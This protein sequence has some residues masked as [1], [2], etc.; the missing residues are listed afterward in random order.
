MGEKDSREDAI[1]A[2]V[3]AAE[4]AI[5]QAHA[6]RGP[7]RVERIKRAEHEHLKHTQR[8]DHHLSQ[9]AGPMINAGAGLDH[10]DEQPETNAFDVPD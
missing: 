9:Q 1:T 5:R 6:S 3:R 4:H 8:L 2:K 7:H 10:E